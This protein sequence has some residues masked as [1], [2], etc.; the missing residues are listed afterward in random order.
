MLHSSSILKGH[1]THKSLYSNTVY[2]PDNNYTLFVAPKH[3]R[4]GTDIPERTGFMYP[5]VSLMTAQFDGR[6]VSFDLDGAPDND[7]L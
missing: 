2:I 5:I 1:I 4:M 3:R 7:C 6:A